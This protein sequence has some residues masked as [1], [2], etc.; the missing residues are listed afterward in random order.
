MPQTQQQQP[1]PEL[2][3]IV[4]RAGANL[5]VNDVRLYVM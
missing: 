4:K 1:V 5:A 3:H 2:K